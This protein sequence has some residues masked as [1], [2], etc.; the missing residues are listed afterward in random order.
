MRS[1]WR[2]P[3]EL[4]VRKAADVLNYC[5]GSGGALPQVPYHFEGL[6]RIALIADN[7]F[8][9]ERV[10]ARSEPATMATNARPLILMSLDAP[11]E[12]GSGDSVVTLERYQTVLIAAAS[13]WC[14]VRATAG[15]SAP[16]MF[17]TPP[18]NQQLL[19]ARLIAAVPD[20]AAAAQ[21]ATAS[22]MPRTGGR[23]RPVLRRPGDGPSWAARRRGLAYRAGAGTG[24][25]GLVPER[26]REEAMT[27]T[28]MRAACP[29]QAGAGAQGGVPGTRA[30]GTSHPGRARRA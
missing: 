26:H 1:F 11:M 23:H 5:A 17:V 21:R 9:V 30:A 6:D 10:V 19:A 12:V 8:V 2:K 27:L 3:R 16:F 4:H 7:H 20:I 22:A 28:L 13:E 18:E 24:R 15:D 14:T 29:G 25:P